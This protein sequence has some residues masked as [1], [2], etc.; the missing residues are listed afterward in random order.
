M[1]AVNNYILLVDYHRPR[2]RFVSGRYRV[3]AK[4][5]KEAIVLLRKSIGM[6][7]IQVYYQCRQD[8]PRNVAYKCVVKEEM[9]TVTRDGRDCLMMVHIEPLRF[10]AQRQKLYLEL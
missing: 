10:N 3:G 6:G 8:D 7:S 1:R 2:K 5:K 4:D 9:K